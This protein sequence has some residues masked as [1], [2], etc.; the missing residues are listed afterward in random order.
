MK[1]VMLHV[2]DDVPFNRGIRLSG[3][4]FFETE[5]ANARESLAAKEREAYEFSKSALQTPWEDLFTP[6]REVVKM[7]LAG[8]SSMR[9]SYFS[10]YPTFG[11][12]DKK[13]ARAHKPSPVSNPKKCFVNAF[14]SHS[15]NNL[16]SVLSKLGVGLFRSKINE[17]S[18]IVFFLLA[19]SNP[20]SHE[21]GAS[22]PTHRDLQF[23]FIREVTKSERAHISRINQNLTNLFPVAVSILKTSKVGVFKFLTKLLGRSIMQTLLGYMPPETRD[24]YLSP[25]LRWQKGCPVHEDYYRQ[26]SVGNSRIVRGTSSGSLWFDSLQTHYTAENDNRESTRGCVAVRYEP[27]VQTDSKS[28]TRQAVLRE[29][30]A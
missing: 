27:P 17:W 18:R 22:P 21:F 8:L 26:E 7:H 6:R 12:L 9:H 28:F 15:F 29:R 23:L 30:A 4:N 11:L 5:L 1:L 3:Q 20:F 10:D 14:Q 2:D 25:V 13:L 16:S 24:E 19:N